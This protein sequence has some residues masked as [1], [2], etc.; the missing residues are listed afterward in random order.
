MN[1]FFFTLLSLTFILISLNARDLT[2]LPIVS[3][4]LVKEEVVYEHLATMLES[5]M[6]FA[7]EHEDINQIHSDE[8]T[9]RIVLTKAMTGFLNFDVKK[10]DSE[11]VN[12]D[13]EVYVNNVIQLFN[14]SSVSGLTVE[15]SSIE[16][17]RPDEKETT[18]RLRMI[19][20]GY[21]FAIMQENNFD[22][23]NLKV[24]WRFKDIQ[25]KMHGLMTQKMNELAKEF[26]TMLFKEL[27]ERAQKFTASFQTSHQQIVYILKSFKAYA[28]EILIDQLRTFYFN[29]TQDANAISMD[30]AKA[31]FQRTIEMWMV[32]YKLCERDCQPKHFAS[33]IPN[34]LED[35]VLTRIEENR[36]IVSS[37]LVKTFFSK[38]LAFLFQQNFQNNTPE[39]DNQDLMDLNENYA[40]FVYRLFFSKQNR[41]MNEQLSKFMKDVYQSQ[42]LNYLYPE[43]DL[44]ESDLDEFK[45]RQNLN[46]R[47]II[48]LILHLD[49]PHVDPEAEH[50]ADMERQ[51]NISFT[52]EDTLTLVRAAATWF[53]YDLDQLTGDEVT[54]NWFVDYDKPSQF[55]DYLVMYENLLEF[56]RTFDGEDA[57][58]D[59]DMWL[60]DYLVDEV[61]SLPS[62]NAKRQERLSLFWIM[63]NINMINVLSGDNYDEIF[64]NSFKK[65]TNDEIITYF[66]RI[67]MREE[68]AFLKKAMLQI[69]AYYKEGG[70]VYTTDL[71]DDKFLYEVYKMSI[72]CEKLPEILG[73]EVTTIN[74][75]FKDKEDTM[76]MH[77]KK[78]L[79]NGS[80]SSYDWSKRTSENTEEEIVEVISENSSS[81]N[82]SPIT[83]N[84]PVVNPT[85]KVEN[86]SQSSDLYIDTLFN[87]TDQTS[88]KTTESNI[89]EKDVINVSEEHSP[90][91]D[92]ESSS[93]EVV[94]LSS[95]NSETQDDE[96]PQNSKNSQVLDIEENSQVSEHSIPKKVITSEKTSEVHVDLSSENS[97]EIQET[98]VSPTK[99]EKSN[100][101]SE[102]HVDLSSENSSEIQE[103]VVSPTKIDK[104]EKTPE[105]HVDLSSENSS[106]IQEVV[107][108]PTKIEKSNKTSE[109]HVD[110]SSEN[111]SEI[112]ETVVSPSKI[113][114][115]YRTSE[116]SP[117][118]IDLSENTSSNV[119]V[120]ETIENTSE[121]TPEVRHE[122]SSPS[123]NINISEN[124]VSKKNTSENTQE[125]VIEE[126]LSSE[127]S[128]IKSSPHSGELDQ[129]KTNNPSVNSQD[130]ESVISEHI[131]VEISENSD[132]KVETTPKTSPVIEHNEDSS[133]NSVSQNTGN[134]SIAT[135]QDEVEEQVISHKTDLDEDII[136]TSSHTSSHNSSEV[137]EDKEVILP[138]VT[139]VDSEVSSPVNE[140]IVDQDPKRHNLV[141]EV[142][143]RLTPEQRK[144][145]EFSDDVFA[146]IKDLKIQVDE[147]G[148]ETEYVYVQIVRKDSDC[149]EELLKFA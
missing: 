23:S 61:D 96:T 67:T 79:D 84:I 95:E 47:Y 39:E 140:V 114:K 143:G 15:V 5:A 3:E 74:V 144:T 124:S 128:S 82:N 109:V 28:T 80:E 77:R 10:I 55:K 4:F 132:V 16:A 58:E 56:K 100:K 44:M 34:F 43:E 73:T 88:Y 1:K 68:F 148:V 137:S 63:K 103:V 87:N 29:L 30:K 104:S 32:A 6:Q 136:E 145:F 37:P 33:L 115:S 120:I 112:D 27:T 85:K 40:M 108:S 149:Y 125:V 13:D 9:R 93:N 19:M 66:R 111:S 26:Q 98:I 129:K 138:I 134:N 127:N 130:D 51:Q 141:Y 72:E 53:A 41:K 142:T 11:L 97:S 122:E 59:L 31:T 46:Q 2:P 81:H 135:I 83:E 94:V 22:D 8:A 139:P 62:D 123:Q 57:G 25:Q 117:A 99:I 12:S 105:V 86:S 42:G 70:Q 69:Y 50:T 49:F 133:E 89:K 38:F 48:D 110:L 92:V 90:K 75:T 24:D 17:S 64:A 36:N 118:K 147:Y 54:L 106:E 18:D 91:V 52:E 65:E 35:L 14:E 45:R 78:T 119:D 126:D 21:Y 102:V 131:I 146:S 113:D 76:D 71:E 101:T 121:K 60:Q 7:V 107:V 116:S 20:M